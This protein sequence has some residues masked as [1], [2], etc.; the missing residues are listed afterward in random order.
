[1]KHLLLAA[2]LLLAPGARA[3]ST[4][5]PLAAQP[6]HYQ[7]CLLYKAGN[8]WH[9][10]YGQ[11]ARPAVVNA[12]LRDDNDAIMKLKSEVAALNYLDGRGWEYVNSTS[13]SG[14][15]YSGRTDYLLRRRLP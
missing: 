9:L 8:T 5:P 1:M 14:S 6:V 3:Q 13:Y 7:Y 2:G 11:D 4:P 10:D 12:G 15:T